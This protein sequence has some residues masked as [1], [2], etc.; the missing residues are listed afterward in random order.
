MGECYERNRVHGRVR[1]DVSRI[2]WYTNG[3]GH[4]GYGWR[5]E[6]GDPVLLHGAGD[7]GEDRGR[8]RVDNG[9]DSE[10]VGHGRYSGVYASAWLW[11]V[12]YSVVVV[13]RRFYCTP[14]RYKRRQSR[15]IQWVVGHYGKHEDPAE[16]SREGAVR[17]GSV[18]RGRLQGALGRPDVRASTVILVALGAAVIG[19][20][21][22]NGKFQP[23]D[24]LAGAFVLFVI[25]VADNGKMAPVAKGFAWLFLAAVLLGKSSPLQGLSKAIS[26]PTPVKAVK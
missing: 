8:A 7:S 13:Y 11:L 12:R 4:V 5:L 19:R 18:Q 2:G 23:K 22:T 26:T 15:V 10:V 25:T 9:N 16:H 3:Y 24:I 20:W 21:T 1:D 14:V 17:C 6:S